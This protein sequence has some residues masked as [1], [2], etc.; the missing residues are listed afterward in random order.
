MIR[1]VFLWREGGQSSLA[2]AVGLLTI[3]VIEAAFFRLLMPTVGGS[4]LS[5]ES[6]HP[7]GVAAIGLIT[8]TTR[9]DE[10]HLSA[11]RSAAKALPKKQ[12]ILGQH[13]A[14]KRG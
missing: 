8:V 6:R 1:H 2:S 4:S 10:E 3:K 14:A 12:L 13:R 11:L 9:A 5:A 7:A